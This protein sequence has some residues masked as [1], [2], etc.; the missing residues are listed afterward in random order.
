MIKPWIGFLHTPKT[1]SCKANITVASKHSQAKFNYNACCGQNQQGEGTHAVL[2]E[3]TANAVMRRVRQSL[4][5]RLLEESSKRG[6]L[7]LAQA[8]FS[9]TT[10]LSWSRLPFCDTI[11]RQNVMVA[12]QAA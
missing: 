12:L 6:F 9:K 3:F 11:W 1:L 10:G 2:R 7:A 8:A 5:G 4:H